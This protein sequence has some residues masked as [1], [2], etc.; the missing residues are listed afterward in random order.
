MRLGRTSQSLALY[1]ALR[2]CYPTLIHASSLDLWLQDSY[3]S[4]L[5]SI[6]SLRCNVITRK[7]GPVWNGCQT[8]GSPSDQASLRR[9]RSRPR[10]Q[11]LPICKLAAGLV[12]STS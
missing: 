3:P 10:S 11:C 8:A 6:T 9:S 4:R 1:E 12:F 5:T 2:G 7:T